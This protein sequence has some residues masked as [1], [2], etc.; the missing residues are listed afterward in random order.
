MS[1]D[2]VK[3]KVKIVALVLEISWTARTADEL[4]GFDSKNERK[5]EELTNEKEWIWKKF[6]IYIRH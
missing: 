1:I 5:R 2:F 3:K 4:S 6:A